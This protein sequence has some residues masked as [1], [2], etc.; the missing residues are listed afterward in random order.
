MRVSNCNSAAIGVH[1]GDVGV[2]PNDVGAAVTRQ[3]IALDAYYPRAMILTCGRLSLRMISVADGGIST[4]R[5]VVEALGGR[6]E[7]IAHLPKGDIRMC[8]SGSQNK[9]N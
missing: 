2:T 6:L 7:V 1:D 4:L 8:Q 9:R 3:D 5:R